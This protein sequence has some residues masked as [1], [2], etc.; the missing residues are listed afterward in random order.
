MSVCRNSACWPPSLPPSSLMARLNPS[1]A[2]A[3]SAANGPEMSLAMPTLI[4]S[5]LA[6]P[7]ASAR[8]ASREGMRRMV[9]APCAWRAAGVFL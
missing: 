6:R 7:G 9:E 4:G 1:R 8:A 3:P 5:A 2:S